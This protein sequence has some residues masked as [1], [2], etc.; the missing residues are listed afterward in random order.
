MLK[1]PLLFSYILIFSHTVIY[2]QIYCKALC[3]QNSECCGHSPAVKVFS[4][5][6]FLSFFLQNI[7]AVVSAFLFRMMSR[8]AWMRCNFILHRLFQVTEEELA[9]QYP[10]NSRLSL[11][12]QSVKVLL[13]E[14]FGNNFLFISDWAR[15][16]AGVALH[17]AISAA[18]I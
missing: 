15:F 17:C 14:N 9:F 6:Y 13:L 10:E 16:I 3:Q 11:V 18:L 2:I 5:H 7:N 4:L 1:S 12:C 8:A